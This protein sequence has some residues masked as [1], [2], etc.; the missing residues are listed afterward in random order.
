MN[1]SILRIIFIFAILTFPLVNGN[2]FAETDIK[3]AIIP[4]SIDAKQPNRQMKTKIPLM[5]SEKLEQEGAKVIFPE[6]APDTE[7]WD[8][9]R[10]RKFGIE[11]GVDYILTGSVF[12][13]GES[14]S[15][16]SRLIN[17]Y[18]KENFTPIYADADNVE[19]LFS[20]ISKISKEIIGQL[21]HKKNITD[22]AITGNKR[23]ESDAILRIIDT[24]VGE[25]LKPDHISKDLRKIYKMGYFDNVII[26]KESLDNGVKLSFEVTEKPSV[27][28]IKFR[29][30]TIYED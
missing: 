6:A 14:I 9:S 25:I 23:V 4:F 22:I 29:Q 17:I 8:F 1:K 18:E 16:D 7:E 15:I 19:N 27:R 10:F 26:K 21:F 13:A 5:I 12:V 20:A 3:V 24:Q 2:L 11:S 28:K 30:N